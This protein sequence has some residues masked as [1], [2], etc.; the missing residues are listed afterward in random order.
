MRSRFAITTLLVIGI[1]M[2]GTG[3]ALSVSGVSGSG[4]SG[5]A[6]YPTTPTQTVNPTTDTGTSTPGDVPSALTP[7]EASD[8]QSTE[9]VSSGDTL[10]FTGFA[11]IPVLI[12]GLVLLGAG[13]VLRRGSKSGEQS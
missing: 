3:A 8:V 4:S 1:I 2:C 5:D 11:A 10:P 6:Q 13:L 12:G 9:Q 7:I